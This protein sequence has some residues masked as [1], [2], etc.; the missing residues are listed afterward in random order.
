M[1]H[2]HCLSIFNDG[3]KLIVNAGNV[4]NS[5]IRVESTGSLKLLN[6]GT[7]YHHSIGSL[8]VEV[9]GQCDIEH[10]NVLML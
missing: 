4:F 3:A 5:N 2:F 8:E 10:G 7:L 1:G 6:N 9:G